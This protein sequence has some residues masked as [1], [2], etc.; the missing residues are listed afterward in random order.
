MT[1]E[2][3]DCALGEVTT[4][5]K[6]SNTFDFNGES[7]EVVDF[8]LVSEGDGVTLAGKSGDVFTYKDAAEIKMIDVSDYDEVVIRKYIKKSLVDSLDPY[9]AGE[10]TELFS[11]DLAGVSSQYSRVRSNKL[12]FENPCKTGEFSRDVDDKYEIVFYLQC[13]K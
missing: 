12:G 3:L 1:K 13:L 6:H 10:I 5:C 11:N 4:V 8:T 9:D 7:M 2:E